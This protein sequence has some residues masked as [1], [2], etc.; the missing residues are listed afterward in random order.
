ME[1]SSGDHPWGALCHEVLDRGE[2][3]LV[4]KRYLQDL[5]EEVEDELEEELPAEPVKEERVEVAVPL[6]IKLDRFGKVISETEGSVQSQGD[7]INGKKGTRT[8][9]VRKLLAR[10]E[11]HV[12]PD[13]RELALRRAERRAE[14]QATD[15]WA[16]ENNFT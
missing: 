5:G 7:V 10:A 8:M 6:V 16:K 15:L 13:E 12:A 1:A 11:A 9:T 14:K 3:E 2:G 4:L